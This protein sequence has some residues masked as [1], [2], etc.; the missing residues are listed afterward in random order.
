MACHCHQIPSPLDSLVEAQAGGPRRSSLT[1]VSNARACTP[2]PWIQLYRHKRGVK[3]AINSQRFVWRHTASTRGSNWFV[4]VKLASNLPL[5]QC[6]MARSPLYTCYKATCKDDR[7]VW[8]M[9]FGITRVDAT[10]SP[11]SAVQRR[12][13]WCRELPVAHLRNAAWDTLEYAPVGHLLTLDN[14]LA[15]EALLTATAMRDVKDYFTRGG[16]WHGARLGFR[17]SEEARQVA[18]LG[19]RWRED[20][21]QARVQ[22]NLY[23][24]GRP[25]RSSLRRHIEDRPFVRDSAE[26]GRLE[27]WPERT[28]RGRSGPSG[29]KGSGAWQ[30]RGW[31]R[32]SSKFKVHKH[33]P[34]VKAAKRKHNRAA[35]VKKRPAAG[36]YTL[37]PLPT[38]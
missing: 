33:G 23:A 25:D 34:R 16:P 8:L 26:P 24:K 1:C 3:H 12:E 30:R 13:E 11:S 32:E 28:P 36:R 17:G 21:Q 7:G 18:R 14:A 15:E 10:Q 38:R 31:A 19:Y 9:Y 2:R 27:A 5:P 35:Y 20:R 37:K 4:D 29:K 22:V 6:D